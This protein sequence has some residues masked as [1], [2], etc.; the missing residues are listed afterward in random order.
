M[1]DRIPQLQV[2]LF[3]HKDFPPPAAL[4][5]IALAVQAISKSLGHNLLEELKKNAIENCYRLIHDLEG[6]TAEVSA[7]SDLAIVLIHSLLN[8]SLDSKEWENV[9]AVGQEREKKQI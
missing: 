2:G 6:E 4:F 1:S 5:V 3:D 8:R 7:R 9:F